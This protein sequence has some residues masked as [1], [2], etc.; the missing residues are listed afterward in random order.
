[1]KKLIIFGNGELAE[2]AAFYFKFEQ[3]IDTIGFVID[4]KNLKETTFL[5]KS[6]IPLE[7]VEKKFSN[8]K[9]DFHIAIS[10]GGL[11]KNREKKF[12]EIN[13]MNYKFKNFISRN[14][15]ISPK[16]K[17]FGKNLF[18]L[19]NQVIQNNVEIYDNVMI[20]SGNHIGHASKIFSHSYISSHC[21]IS[22]HCEIGER[23]FVGVNTSMAD[24]T[25]VGK[26]T[27]VGMSSSISGKIKEGSTV[28]GKKVKFLKLKVNL[29]KF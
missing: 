23:C 19:E 14:S 5:N 28:V 12:N 21:V 16:V 6:I 20:W 29:T 17:L 1:M 25:S 13:K 27:F 8:E 7:E 10:Y 11:N 2:L 24:F 15:F 9:Y 22:G 18:I 3:N 26:D 4:G